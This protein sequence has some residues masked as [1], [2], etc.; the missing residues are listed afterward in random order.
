MPASDGVAARRRGGHPTDAILPIVAWGA[1]YRVGVELDFGVDVACA[2]GVDTVFGMLTSGVDRHVRDWLTLP[3][4]DARSGNTEASDTPPA[5]WEMTTSVAGMRPKVMY[6]KTV[7]DGSDSSTQSI[8]DTVTHGLVVGPIGGTPQRSSTTAG[9]PHAPVAWAFVVR[10]ALP[11][12]VCGRR[13]EMSA[14]RGL[15]ASTAGF[16]ATVC[17]HPLRTI[18]TTAR[19][20]AAA[21]RERRSVIDNQATV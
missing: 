1:F 2:G 7:A 11:A 4:A 12:T 10:W 6:R 18:R 19:G 20:N 17:A 13:T 16:I 15:F 21:R 9:L 14:Q 8:P 3:T 5:A